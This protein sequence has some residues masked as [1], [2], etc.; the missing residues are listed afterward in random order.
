MAL[1]VTGLVDTPP[2]G[3][4]NPPHP[5]GGGG[6]GAG[7]PAAYPLAQAPVVPGGVLHV[8]A[9][10]SASSRSPCDRPAQVIINKIGG[11]LMLP[12]IPLCMATLPPMRKADCNQLQPSGHGPAPIRVASRTLALQL[13]NK[14]RHLHRA[15]AERAAPPLHLPTTCPCKA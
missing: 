5:G 6:P 7:A 14:L 4:G 12:C 3:A 13:P 9:V 10:L 15:Y 1:M 2:G 11:R 8:S